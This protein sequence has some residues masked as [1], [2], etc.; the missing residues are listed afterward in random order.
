MGR[1]GNSRHSVRLNLWQD[2]LHFCGARFALCSRFYP[3]TLMRGHS[4]AR[5]EIEFYGCNTQNLSKTMLTI[6]DQEK[7]ISRQ[8]N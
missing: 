1:G 7:T 5:I 8:F 3:A 4:S 6:S 2:A